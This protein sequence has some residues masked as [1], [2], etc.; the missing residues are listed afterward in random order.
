M[1]T[2]LDNKIDFWKFQ[3][4]ELFE[5]FDFIALK[6]VSFML[7]I[8]YS[9]TRV[10]QNDHIF[11]ENDTYSFTKG[12]LLSIPS[13]FDAKFSSPE[14]CFLREITS[15]LIRPE[16]KLKQ[17]QT[18]YKITP[19]DKCQMKNIITRKGQKSV[20]FQYKIRYHCIRP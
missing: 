15:E 18:E 16:P 10:N 12:E 2:V 9:L 7:T 1:H 5:E 20:I 11:Q 17:V 13:T 4:A 6:C 8:Q 14:N 3:N 19:I